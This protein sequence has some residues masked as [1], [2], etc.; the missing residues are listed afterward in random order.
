MKV[1]VSRRRKE[2]GYSAVSIGGAGNQQE[3]GVGIGLYLA[4]E[5]VRK[6]DGYIKVG[7]GT[8][9]G[10]VFEIYLGKGV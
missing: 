3:E 1:L 7:P 9:K 4:R 6:N 5:I 10:S 2:A 8:E